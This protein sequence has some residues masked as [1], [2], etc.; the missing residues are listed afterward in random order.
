[1][2]RDVV[3]PTLFTIVFMLFTGLYGF[4]KFSHQ[5]DYATHHNMVTKAKE[6][7][8]SVS[9]VATPVYHDNLGDEAHQHVSMLEDQH[10]IT[11]FSRPLITYSYV[12]SPTA[13][14]NL[15]FFLDNGLHGAADFIF[16]LNGPTDVAKFIPSRTNIQVVSRPN[17]CFV[18]GAHGEVLRKDGLYKKYS[19]FI[20]LNSDIRGPFLPYSNHG[21]W[22]DAFL[23]QVTEDVKLVGMTANCLPK[24]HIPSMIWAT[25]TLGMEL[26]LNLRE[27][28]SA[29]NTAS[30]NGQ[31]AAFQG[32]YSNKEQA[33]NGEVEATAI[34]KK[35]GY[36]VDALMTAFHA[37]QDYEEYCAKDPVGD[38][39]EDKQYNNTD[40]HPYE[41][42]FIKA[43]RDTDPVTVGRLTDWYQS[44]ASNDT[45]GMC[46]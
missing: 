21:C 45:L 33:F 40:A 43:T 31:V 28:A 20:T 6:H 7:V 42:I 39:L 24:F 12:E 17:E 22:S 26:L 1:M 19:R 23:H 36:E 38:V 16:I 3:T 30:G 41:T 32:C 8:G 10:V 14:E 37:S 29:S 4:V 18:L 5:N 27:D 15:M 34:I 9:A 13:L 2:M 46:G 25:D 44:H 35:A 11:G